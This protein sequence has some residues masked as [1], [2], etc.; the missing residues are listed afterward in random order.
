MISLSLSLLLANEYLS[1]KFM[2]FYCETSKHLLGQIPAFLHSI[3]GLFGFDFY[4]I[5]GQKTQKR[6]Q[7]GCVF[8]GVSSLRVRGPRRIHRHDDSPKSS[9]RSAFPKNQLRSPPCP[10]SRLPTPS[11]AAPD[12]SSICDSGTLPGL[13]SLSPAALPRRRPLQ[14][15]SVCRLPS[16]TPSAHP[17]PYRP[18]LFPDLQ[19]RRAPRSAVAVPCRTPQSV[20]YRLR[21][22]GPPRPLPP[23]TR[24]TSAAPLVHH[25]AGAPPP[26]SPS[27][28]ES[29][30]ELHP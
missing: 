4:P 14:R 21:L 10:S 15:S 30:L 2:C 22:E 6:A 19:L 26:L 23:L 18:R 5:F 3:N 17:V 16:V 20:I 11:S 8:S 1:I 24:R 27:P 29:V 7:T 28:C 13:S 12:S 25:A 9:S